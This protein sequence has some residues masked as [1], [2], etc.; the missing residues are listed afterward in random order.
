MHRLQITL[1][2]LLAMIGTE[3][4]PDSLQYELEVSGMVCAFCAY[5]VSRQLQSLDAIEPRSIDVDLTDGMVRLRSR[6]SLDEG[7]LAERVTAAGFKLKSVSSSIAVPPSE[8]MRA[9]NRLLI[10][11]ELESDGLGRG[12]YDSLLGA[13]GVL[14]VQRAA[15]VRVNGPAGSEMRI[16]RPILMGR[17]RRIDVEY[18]AA[19]EQSKSILIE[20]FVR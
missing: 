12:D 3:S 14:S 11:L 1:F 4:V 20:V 5:N 2:A 7:I 8:P 6:A 16:L 10:R 15:A 17:E 13:L 19:P 18:A 9:T